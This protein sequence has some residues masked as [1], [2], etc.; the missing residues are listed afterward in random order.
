MAEISKKAWK[1][2]HKVLEAFDVSELSG[3]KGA[4]YKEFT[5]FERDVMDSILQY[6][7]ASEKQ[8]KIIAL[9]VA[10]AHTRLYG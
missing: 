6:R 5:Q 3:Y 7:R 4:Y 10:K 2:Y 1:K 9:A 8:M